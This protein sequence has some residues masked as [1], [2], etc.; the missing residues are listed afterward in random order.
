MV[1]VYWG[2]MFA[3]THLSLPGPELPHAP[4]DKTMHFVAYAGLAFL[5]LVAAA[6][7][8]RVTWVMYLIVMIGAALYGAVDEVSQSMVGR[9]MDIADWRFDVMGAA[10]GSIAFAAV[11][12][13]WN[14]WQGRSEEDEQTA[15]RHGGKTG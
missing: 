12:A 2:A 6:T 14:L 1:A 8:G 5:W 3:G 13:V 7:F 4:G 15:E 11:Y 9:D 10:I